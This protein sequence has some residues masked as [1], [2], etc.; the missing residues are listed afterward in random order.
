MAPKDESSLLHILSSNVIPRPQEA[1]FI[2][3]EIRGMKSQIS[4]LRS[5][6]RSLEKR[7]L[8]HE[9]AL[10]ASRKVPFEIL[11]EIFELLLPD[12]LD[13]ADRKTLIDLT[14]VCKNWREAAL[15]KHRLW[16]GISLELARGKEKE[17]P[18]FYCGDKVT[19]WL[20]RA[21]GAPKTLKVAASCP[22]DDCY[23]K[24][25]KKCHLS[26]PALVQLLT[27]TI[28][29]LHNLSLE[30]LFSNCVE[31]LIQAIST[32]IWEA[33][34]LQSLSVKFTEQWYCAAKPAS[35]H[36]LNIPS[37]TTALS[38]TLPRQDWYRGPPAG[39][40]EIA[41][42]NDYDRLTTI[43]LRIDW[44]KKALFDTL[45]LCTK[46]ENLTLDLQNHQGKTT[47]DP[48]VKSYSASGIHLN[49]LRTLK[50]ERID[51]DGA[52]ILQVL[53]AP[54]LADLSISFTSGYRPA[55]AKVN[56][57]RT[58]SVWHLRE[59]AACIATHAGTLSTLRIHDV[60]I[61]KRSSFAGLFTVP[62]PCLKRLTID[63]VEFNSS[64]FDDLK[65]R[66]GDKLFPRLAIL[67][68]LEAAASCRASSILSFLGGG[69]RRTW[70][71]KGWEYIIETPVERTIKHVTIT[72]YCNPAITNAVLQ[73]QPK[74]TL[75]AAAQFRRGGTSFDIG[76]LYIEPKVQ[77]PLK[78][79]MRPGAECADSDCDECTYLAEESTDSQTSEE[80]DEDEEEY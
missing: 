76:P 38:V 11:G 48:I 69:A 46:V 31:N 61:Y 15:Q 64:F 65:E 26:Q 8:Q 74:E 22:E 28:P 77:K 40:G 2:R 37:A 32:P 68:V 63:R 59:W 57:Q 55:G 56:E 16:S 13:D 42:K 72:Y 78:R 58:L 39:T 43:F 6:L 60:A 7:L 12:V 14:L 29:T 75:D 30:A 44:P 52:W 66:K 20:G 25:A 71:S 73:E 36:P 41:L 49:N 10:S 27:I 50:L 3:H 24:G 35:K 79:R 70:T 54:S 4:L 62:L 80:E 47:D 51:R 21:G 53:R 19:S 23:K 5:Q 33:L 9:M 34:P 17:I 18:V 45:A 1:D 67:E